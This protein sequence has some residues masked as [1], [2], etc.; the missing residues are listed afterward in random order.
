MIAGTLL[1][2]MAGTALPF[3]FVII[4]FV[5]TE[6][7]DF[8][9]AD[10]LLSQLANGTVPSNVTIDHFCADELFQDDSGFLTYLS[11]DDPVGLLQGTLFTLSYGIAAIAAAYLLGILLSTILWSFT[12]NNQEQ[13]MKS[14][15]I[16]AVLNQDISQYDLQVSTELSVHLIELAL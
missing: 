2:F 6:F 7:A 11:S 15:F 8:I 9:T 12:A 16:R 14:E 10:M 3:I 1:S 13:R 4:G 5:I